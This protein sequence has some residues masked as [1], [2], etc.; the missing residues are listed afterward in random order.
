MLFFHF[1]PVVV[2][3]FGEGHREDRVAH[4]FSIQAGGIESEAQPSPRL[5][6]VDGKTTV[7]VAGE[8]VTLV[9]GGE[10]PTRHAKDKGIIVQ[11]VRRA[12]RTGKLINSKAMQPGSSHHSTA[13]DDAT[14]LTEALNISASAVT[15]RTIVRTWRAKGMVPGM[16][17]FVQPFSLPGQSG[18]AGTSE[19]ALE[20]GSSHH[21]RT[22]GHDL[23]VPGLSVSNE[24]GYPHAVLESHDRSLQA[25]HSRRID[26]RN[27]RK[28]RQ[29]PIHE[30]HTSTD[31]HVENEEQPGI[32]SE[33]LNQ[34]SSIIPTEWTLLQACQNSMLHA[35]LQIT[36]LVSKHDTKGAGP[37]VDSG[38][39]HSCVRHSH[40]FGDL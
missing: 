4:I 34:T 35:R 23:D 5:F 39:L 24:G 6:H 21:S 15:S 1:L 18:K 38:V 19:A 32:A 33:T 30:N 40:L 16:D 3:P 2:L 17:M 31:A 20:G 10:E 9:D 37:N 29:C 12:H 36:R 26:I 14:N 13:T 11:P 22:T 8:D 25:N 7:V 27:A 28:T